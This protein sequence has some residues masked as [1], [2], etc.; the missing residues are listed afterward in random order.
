MG[1]NIFY[2]FKT[3]GNVKS[4]SDSFEHCNYPIVTLNTLESNYMRARLFQ[5]PNMAINL[6]TLEHINLDCFKVSR[7]ASVDREIP[8]KKERLGRLL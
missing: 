2:T 6:S 7:R 8:F 5:S 1:W 4:C 3:S